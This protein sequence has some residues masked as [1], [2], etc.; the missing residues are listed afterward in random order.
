MFHVTSG[1]VTP[2]EEGLEL[3]GS[4]RCFEVK[5]RENKQ[6]PIELPVPGCQKVYSVRINDAV[7]PPTLEMELP[8]S[9]NFNKKLYCSMPMYRLQ[10]NFEGFP[11]LV[12]HL[13]SNDGY[14]QAGSRIY[15]R[16]EWDAT[17]PDESATQQPTGPVQSGQDVRVTLQAP[18][19][20]K[21]SG[22]SRS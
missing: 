22:S 5:L 2:A 9:R 14:W 13:Y 21:P 3:P 7:L 6:H 12:R 16:A 10:T 15:V 4:V 20:T 18:P 1:Q 19:T 17:V 8:D 11:V